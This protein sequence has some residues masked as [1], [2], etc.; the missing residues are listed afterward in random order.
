MRIDK[1]KTGKMSLRQG[2]KRLSKSVGSLT[3]LYPWGEVSRGL[4]KLMKHIILF[5]D[6]FTKVPDELPAPSLS[7][8]TGGR[9]RC[10]SSHKKSELVG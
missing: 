7:S 1:A 9:E 2:D 6:H 4:F 3:S 10:L 5:P 8:M